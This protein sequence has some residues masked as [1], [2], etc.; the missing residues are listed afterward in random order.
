MQET[1]HILNSKYN[2]AAMNMAIDEALLHFHAEGSIR[3]TI[4]FYGWENPSL[5]IGH[6]QKIDKAINLD[7]VH[8]HQCDFVRRLTGG[9]AVLHDDEITYSIVVKE[10][11]PKIPRSINEAY[12]VLAQGLLEGYKLLGIEAAFAEQALTKDRTAVCFEQPAIY[13]MLVDGKKISGNAQTR[14]QGVLL[15]HGSV[16]MSFDLDMLFD[17]FAFPSERVK[18]RQ[19][20]AFKQKAT[21]INDITNKTHTYDMLYEAFLQGFEKSLNIKTTPLQLTEAQ[22]EYIHHL[23]DTKYRTDEWNIT[24]NKPTRSLAK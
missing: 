20:A 19:K 14:K 18:E 13:E 17:L 11:H 2:D 21:S 24:K 7:G 16:P 10:D 9:S 23:A 1:W 4:R 8:K 12:Y 15:Q 5:T 3:P 6:F 22:W